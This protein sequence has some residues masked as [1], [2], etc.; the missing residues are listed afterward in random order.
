MSLAHRVYRG[1]A[2]SA[3]SRLDLDAIRRDNPLPAIAG[4]VV[5]LQARGGE[6]KGCCPFHADRSPSFTIFSGGRRYHCFGCGSSGDVLDFVGRLHGVG[7]RDAAEM[8]GAGDLPTIEVAPMRDREEGDSDRTADALAIWAASV[9]AA[10]TLAETYLRW[11]GLDL[12]IP[13]SIRFASLTAR[14]RE[15][16]VLVAAVT[17]A[18]DRVCGIQ[19]TYLADDGCGKADMPSPK[20]SLGRVRGGAIRLAPV[21]GDLVVAEGLED[22]LT[23]QQQLGVAAW[24]AAGASNLSSMRFPPTVRRVT[25]GGDNDETGRKAAG[26]AAEAFALRGVEARVFFPAP[27]FKDHNDEL[28]GCR[29]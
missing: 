2:R 17:G 22:G 29:A 15:Y 7:L 25:V 27:G 8:L 3:P 9:P 23:L 24:A 20:L 21:A 4:A 14:R 12:P 5:K 28:R 18:D 11:R 10:G 1:E 16:P 6:W 26:K 13:D 19:R